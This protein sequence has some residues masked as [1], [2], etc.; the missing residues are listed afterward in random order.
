MK[1]VSVVSLLVLVLAA[2]SSPAF[3][4][5]AANGGTSHGTPYVT[6]G[7]GADSRQALR[8]RE[9]EYNLMVM[10]ALK[11]G[12]Y[13]G[14]GAVS[15]HDRAGKTMLEVDATGPWIFAKLP[16]GKYTVEVR[17]GGTVR[18]QQFVIGNKGIKRVLLTWD[19]EPA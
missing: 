18:S 8:A 19:K 10:L 4:Q 6:G 16:P 15:V 2:G 14:G 7:I 9:G 11:D 17:K 13:L 1:P 12:S 5:D 3:A